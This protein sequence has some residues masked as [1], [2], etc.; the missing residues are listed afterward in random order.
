MK[1][2]LLFLLVAVIAISVASCCKHTIKYC[3]P[4]STLQFKEIYLVAVKDF[5]DQRPEQERTGADKQLFEFASRDEHFKTPVTEH[6]QDVFIKE[7]KEASLNAD[8]Y[9]KI[10]KEQY[11]YILSGTVKHFQA[12]MKPSKVSVVPY[13]G[14][15]VSIWTK[16]RFVLAVE[17]EVVLKDSSGEIMLD[18]LY[19]FEDS[20][21]LPT[22]LFNLARYSRGFNYKLQLL[23]EA[24]AE[25]AKNIRNDVL[26]NIHQRQK[27]YRTYGTS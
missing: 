1:R 7:F 15:A 20:K 12:I 5:K 23:D 16:D 17:I 25:V 24:L 10:N 13:L 6:L 9:N 21:K 11:D 4:E 22:G 2:T 19:S 26:K 14:T 27:T 18:Q 8:K 3:L